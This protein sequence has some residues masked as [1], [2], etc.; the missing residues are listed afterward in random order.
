MYKVKHFTRFYEGYIEPFRIIDSVYFC[1]VYQSSSHLIDT[2]DGLLLIDAGYDYTLPLLIDSIHRLGFD[3]KD[4]KYIFSTHRHFDHTDGNE[5]MHALTGAKVMIGEYDANGTELKYRPDIK[6]RDGDV[7]KM[8]NKEFRFMWTPGH[9][10]GTMSVFFDTV[11]NGVTYRVG[12]FGGAGSNT[13]ERGNIEYYDG[14][15]EDYINS[16]DRLDKEHVDIFIGNHCWNNDTDEKGRILRE[17][18]EN[19]FIDPEEFHRF[20]GHCRKRCIRTVER[21]NQREEEGTLKK[22]VYIER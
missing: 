7:L 4:I 19:R 22:M 14:C 11:D 9:T 1:G 17:T 10:R 5:L 21:D 12:M 18:G 15:I 2:G 6:L 13:L 8:G 16:L 20:I 3:P